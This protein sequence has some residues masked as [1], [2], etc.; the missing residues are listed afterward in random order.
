MPRQNIQNRRGARVV[1][2]ILSRAGRASWQLTPADTAPSSG[3]ATRSQ[4]ETLGKQRP[5]PEAHS[6]RVQ[7][8]WSHDLEGTSQSASGL[9][10]PAMN[11]AWPAGPLRRVLKQRSEFIAIDKTLMYK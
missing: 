4:A 10:G 2:T 9:P 7:S 1:M 6:I 5:F 3:A 11:S 8:G